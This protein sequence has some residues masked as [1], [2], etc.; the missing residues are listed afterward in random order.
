[1]NNLKSEY[2]ALTEKETGIVDAGTRLDW[3]RCPIDRE[4]LL[5]L[6]KKN[7]WRPLLHN[8]GLLG[9][10]AAT[11]LFAF[12]AFHNLAWPWV[13]LAT[14][15]HCSFYGFFGSGAGGHELSHK[16]MFKSLWLNE[17]FIR[18]NGFLTWFNFI[19]F[20]HSH[21]K[22]HQYTVHHNLDLEIEL[23]Q[24]EMKWWI[25]LIHLFVSNIIN[26][27]AIFARLF[28]HTFSRRREVILQTE[29]EQR[30]FPA[31]EP[32]ELKKLV[33]W[34]RIMIFGHT[35]LALIFILTGNWILLFLVTFALFGPQWFKYLTHQPQHVGMKPDVADWRH[36]T[37]TYLAGPIVRFFYWNMNY[38]VEHHMFAAVPFYNLPKLR[39]TL[40]DDLPEA[41][42]G[43]IATWK[44]IKST[45]KRQKEDPGY[46]KPLQYPANL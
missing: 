4:K 13:V 39:A 28:R 45:L 31:S 24:K 26:T 1:M 44:E 9:F 34:S 16:N 18:I 32:K 43:L 6:N 35:G 19:N 3:Y 41:P 42:R 22:H 11:G 33:R 5:E 30:C 17:L 46:Y 14:Y 40:A 15:F 27:P 8:L 7:N 21:A 36:G 10:S 37:R 2:S 38:H 20:R 25:S 29:W 23:P 12:W